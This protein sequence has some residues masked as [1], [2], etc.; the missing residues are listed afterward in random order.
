[1]N[2]VSPCK[3]NI[4]ILFD[5]LNIK[6][7]VYVDDYN[8][9]IDV[10][11]V[12]TSPKRSLILETC[13]PDLLMDDEDIENAKL[14]KQWEDITYE[15]KIKI[16]QIMVG[17]V[18]VS[19]ST[20]KEAIPV[21]AG[22]IPDEILLSLSPERW[23]Q[24]KENLLHEGKTTLFLFD[25]D[26]KKD[27]KE[28]DGIEIIKN[29]SKNN[30]ILCG[31]FTQKAE[32][33]DCLQY[34][35]EMCEKYIIDKDKFFVVPKKSVTEN[36]LLFVYL[37]RLT[38]LGKV[39]VNFKTHA[40]SIIKE[41][42]KNVEKK[43]DEIR[44][45]D[46]DQ[47][48]FKT[49][50]KEGSWEPDMFFRIYSGFQRRDFVNLASSKDELKEAISKIRE[51]SGIPTK[52][53]SFLIPSEAW[54]IQHQELYDDA[55]YLNKNHLPIEV[56]DIFEKVNKDS[57][58]KYIL[59]TQPC[60]LM[61]RSDGERARINK[62]FTLLKMTPLEKK[63]RCNTY[64]QIVWY[65]GTSKNE[66]WKVNFRDIIFT[67]D[68]ILDLCV[69]ND[70]GVSKY[71]SALD[72]DKNSIRPSLINRYPEIAS[73]INDRIKECDEIL[74]EIKKESGLNSDVINKNVYESLFRD[75]LFNPEYKQNENSFILT[76]NCKRTGRLIYE[77]ATGLLAE[78]YSVM[79]RPAYPPD[80]GQEK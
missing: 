18:D 8:I 43:I 35:D 7:V 63:E 21:F 47:I 27:R 13:F 75:D 80:Y 49:P 44:I 60:D 5:V 17:D 51:V 42:N 11:S 32:E 10:E 28:E 1:M 26:L 78:F 56:G 23:E 57:T 50:L 46:F 16:K 62:R 25:Q 2:D 72:L 6:K 30:E 34:R 66:R 73:Q 67:K 15:T 52:P 69:F 39:F 76:F 20:D 58:D 14:K 45:E 79:Q 59:L 71:S 3:E 9:D 70:D 48:I 54:N 12:I 36:K 29:I 65:Y 53:I 24:E 68:Y 19:S 33:D 61:I 37:L 77:R 4:R 31:L 22:L 40:N 55:V 74:A 64:E 38:V 41:A